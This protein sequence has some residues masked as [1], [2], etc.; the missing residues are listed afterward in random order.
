MGSDV[1]ED[2]PPPDWLDWLGKGR[3]EHGVDSTGGPNAERLPVTAPADP[4]RGA[5][6][7]DRGGSEVAQRDAPRRPVRW[8]STIERT[9]RTVVGVQL[10]LPRANHW[11]RSSATVVRAPTAG[12]TFARAARSTSA[13]SVSARSPHTV[14]V[15][16]RRF[17]VAESV[18]T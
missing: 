16:Q 15:T 7:V 18:P 11:S 2:P 14:R 3:M 4:E 8:V 9:L 6:V 1:V 17:P 13:R 12:A 10:A 5:D